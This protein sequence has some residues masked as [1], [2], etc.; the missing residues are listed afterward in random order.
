MNEDAEAVK[1][2]KEK[3]PTLQNLEVMA[4]VRLPDHIA[5][6]SLSGAMW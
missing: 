5:P 4:A 3:L 2:T 6:A 1:S